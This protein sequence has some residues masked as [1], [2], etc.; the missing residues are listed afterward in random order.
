[1]TDQLFFD[2]DCVSS[3]LWVNQENLILQLYTGRIVL[4]QEVFNE[5]SHPSIPHIMS[6][7]TAMHANGSISTFAIKT[8]TEEYNLYYELTIAPQKGRRVIGKGE[9]AA[10]ALA[11]V[12]KGI[13][14]SNNLKDISQ[15]I[16][17]YNLDYI[18]TCDILVESLK[19]GLIN[20]NIGNQIWSNMLRKRR[21][22]PTLTFTD[23]LK[24]V[25]F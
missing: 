23:Y 20:E 21:A 11:K 4:P 5:L 18:T 13:I 8:N 3:F 1:M 10:L 9:A 19:K 25:Q 15:Y 7:L 16:S 24:T 22:L 14:A 2:T 17:L 12:H 6:K